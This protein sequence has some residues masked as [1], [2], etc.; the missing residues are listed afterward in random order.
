MISKINE[1]GQSWDIIVIGGGASGLGVALEA[2]TRGYKTLLLE[3]HDFAKGTSSKSTKLI[4]GGVR[5]LAQ[6]NIKLVMGALRE[7]GLLRKNAPHLVKDLPFIIPCYRWWDIFLYTVGLTLYDVLAGRLGLG[8][9]LPLSKSAALKALPAI[10]AHKLK[11]GVVYHDGQFDDSRMAV[12]LFQS[13]CAH[14]GLALNYMQVSELVKEEGK[15]IGVVAVDRE[16]DVSYTLKSKVVVNATGIFVNDILKMDSPGAR[17]AV[18]PSQGVHLVVDSKFLNGRDALM[19]PKTP[20]GRVLFAIPWHNRVVIGTTDVEK[21]EAELEP[22][23]TEEEIDYILETAGRYYENP[24]KR[25]DILSVFA[26]LRPLAAPASEGKKTKE[27]S[28]G[29]KILTSKSGLFTLTG[30]KWTIYREMGEDV[31]DK[32]EA[33]SGWPKTESVTKHTKIHG[34]MDQ[35]DEHAIEGAVE[36][37]VEA[38]VEATVEVAFESGSLDWYGSDEV[39]LRKMVD[40]SPEMGKFI[41]EKLRI[42]AAQLILAVR[43]EMARSIEDFLARRVR[44][45]QL[46]AAE[47]IRM[48]PEVARLM[49]K[50]MGKD[51]DWVEKQLEA[52]VELSKGYI[53]N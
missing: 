29:H 43:E 6:G 22:H 33:M 11:G 48:A 38:T 31:I 20:D 47:S 30:G 8:R 32:V 25:E 23:A 27:I 53:V 41:S 46:D 40:E 45:L 28:R 10:K 4:H 19:I 35:H 17:D 3:Q 52:Y 21:E 50:E 39:V 7:R 49:A 1:A 18:V 12:N 24:P 9:S 13:I 37:A 51:G 36:G 42:I 5:Y 34:F 16:T 2:A 15:V 26:G 14:G 44:A